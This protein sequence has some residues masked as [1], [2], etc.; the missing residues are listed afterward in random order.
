MYIEQTPLAV[1]R[2]AYF[3]G[4]SA[5]SSVQPDKKDRRVQLKEP[6]IAEVYIYVG[7]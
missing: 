2:F 1:V 6:S 5:E 3:S 7:I 4:N